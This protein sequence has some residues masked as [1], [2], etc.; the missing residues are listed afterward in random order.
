[1]L[2][3]RDLQQKTNISPNVKTKQDD[4]HGNNESKIFVYG[5][6]LDHHSRG[7]ATLHKNITMPCHTDPRLHICNLKQ[8]L[9]N[10]GLRNEILVHIFL[11]TAVLQLV[12]RNQTPTL[13]TPLAITNGQRINIS[14]SMFTMLPIAKQLN[15]TRTARRAPIETLTS[16]DGPKTVTLRTCAATF[17]PRVLPSGRRRETTIPTL[18]LSGPF[19]LSHSKTNAN[20]IMLCVSLI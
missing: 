1:M 4:A 19:W 9:A 11:A 16:C 2:P 6:R 8:N 18:A 20:V 7:A 15:Q 12:I 17:A 5:F 10:T 3:T 13:A 14:T